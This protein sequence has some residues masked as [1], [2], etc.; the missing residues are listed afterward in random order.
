MIYIQ[1]VCG[2]Q[3]PFVTNDGMFL[4]I[5]TWLSAI[6]LYWILESMA[7]HA[8][9]LGW[10]QLRPLCVYC[11]DHHRMLDIS[12]PIKH[13]TVPW[14]KFQYQNPL[15]LKYKASKQIWNIW[16]AQWKHWNFIWG[17]LTI[18]TLNK[19]AERCNSMCNILS[20]DIPTKIGFIC[21][22]IENS[23]IAH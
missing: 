21:I 14:I 18:G 3:H 4:R 6:L 22:N 16:K 2:Q 8:I 23:F 20:F 7:Y 19:M 17:W 5:E 11:D 10:P 13:K 9:F 1:S 12:M 15:S